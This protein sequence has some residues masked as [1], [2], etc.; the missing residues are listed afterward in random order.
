MTFHRFLRALVALWWVLQRNSLVRAAKPDLPF[1]DINIIVVTDVHSFIGGHPHEVDRNA[2][3]GDVL[4][5]YQHVKGHCNK[6]GLDLWFFMNGDWVHGTG[7]AMDGNATMLLPLLKKMPWDAVNLGNH[8][9][10][11]SAIVELMRDD[12]IPHFGDAF[13]TSN[14]LYAETMEPFGGARYRLLKG[15]KSTLLV[16]GFLYDMHNPSEL[17]HISTV[18][19]TLA[20][21][22]F[23]DALREHQY[24]AICVLAHMDNDDALVDAILHKIRE[25]THEHMPV[26]FLTGHTHLRKTR[27]VG[28]DMW[29]W[30][31][32][33]GGNLDTVGFLSIPTKKT[34]ESVTNREVGGLFQTLFLNANKE[35][36]QQR[37]GGGAQTQE[38]AALAQRINETRHSLG[39]DEIVGC[40]PRDYFINR[41]IHDEDSVF[42]L[43]MDHVVPTQI[44]KTQ[45]DC[46]MFISSD[47]FRYDVRGSGRNDAITVDDIVAIV[48]YME[49]VI[50]VGE[51]PEWVVR[52]MNVSMNTE[53]LHHHRLIPDYLIA[54]EFKDVGDKNKPY[55][56][57]THEYNLPEVMHDLDRLHLHELK[58]KRTDLK[59]TLYW[60][61]YA[62]MAWKCKDHREPKQ[63]MPWFADIKE[64]DEE[65]TDGEYTSGNID[66]ELDK[67]MDKE[68]HNDLTDKGSN[69]HYE[70]YEGYLPPAAIQQFGDK[71]P[72][73]ITPSV[74]QK[75]K[76]KVPAPTAIK[77]TVKHSAAA[78]KAERMEHRKKV[79]KTIFK[80]MGG[81]VA[82]GLLLIPACGLYG[83]FFPDKKRNDMSDETFYDMKEMRSLKRR[84]KSRGQ[85][86]HEIQ[87]T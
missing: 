35:V 40:P 46:V 3:Y 63:V 54:G 5:F 18:E 60:L 57:Y 26:Q 16:F 43:W 14:T 6:H 7:L 71:L 39:L 8:E 65:D 32:E 22:W 87:L 44:F 80:V 45:K 51:V 19:E 69:L 20:Q 4:S 55:R 70:G 47:Y 1:G 76:D 34:A 33:A 49:P 24:D 27:K 28:K 10:Y 52:R 61:E 56:L 73:G 74:P 42:K 25:H 78:N 12:M 79:K 59:D 41:S 38:G 67:E 81:L 30:A 85:P 13:L 86:I 23:R 58:P 11:H 17:L 77:T 82:F 68:D 50:Y 72:P 83:V 64:L 48:P 53:S 21:D 75:P 66:T 9:I 29:G 15:T 37:G 84:G 31:T 2:N 62:E 36:L